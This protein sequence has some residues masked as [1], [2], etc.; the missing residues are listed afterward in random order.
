MGENQPADLTLT[1]LISF[2]E[3]Q[4]Q[5]TP[6]HNLQ[7]FE[8]SDQA[9]DLDGIKHSFNRTMERSTTNVSTL[10]ASSSSTVPQDNSVPQS[11]NESENEPGVTEDTDTS[12]MKENELAA[13]IP[14]GKTLQD[15]PIFQ[16]SRANSR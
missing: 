3:P 4:S 2:I 11:F 5:S 16:V 9:V 7:V 14:G 1:E 12:Q 8:E 15:V 13:L 10:L 6:E